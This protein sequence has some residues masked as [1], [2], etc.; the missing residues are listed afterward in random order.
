[1]RVLLVALQQTTEGP[2]S[3]EE[4]RRWTE[5]GAP[6]RAARLEEDHALALVSA[7]RDGG[8]LAPMLLCQ[9]NSRL[10]DRKSVV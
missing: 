10:Q 4:Q 6:M 7:M 3:P 9:K 8:R 1:M 5:Q 2:A